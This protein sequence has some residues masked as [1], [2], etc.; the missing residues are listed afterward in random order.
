MNPLISVVIPVYNTGQILNETVDSVLSQTYDKFEIIIVDDGSTDNTAEIIKSLERK[1]TRIKYHC[2]SNTGLPAKGRNVGVELSKGD[3]IAFLD[4]DDL[5][6]SNKLEKQINVVNQDENIGLVNTNAF[7]MYG[8]QK[9]KNQ[10]FYGLKEGYFSENNLFPYN[11]IVQS[12]SLI[13]KEAFYEIGKLNEDPDLKAIEDYDL[14]LRLYKKYP[15]YFIDECL[16]YYRVTNL[17]ASAN[18]IKMIEKDLHHYNNYFI[19]YDFPDRIKKARLS[20]IYYRKAKYL[21]KKTDI[22]FLIYLIKAFKV[23]KNIFY[24]FNKLLFSNKKYLMK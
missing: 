23:N 8:N 10:I 2:Q 14:W 13:Y 24:F 12:T 18:T 22:K 17:S 11:T 1:D 6:F 21:F 4:H 20:S 7:L 16:V 3:Y 19:K 5:W 15:C 9:T